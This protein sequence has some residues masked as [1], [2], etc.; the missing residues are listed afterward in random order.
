[1]TGD[2]AVF[3]IFD[4]SM[5]HIDVQNLKCIDARTNLKCIDAQ[6]RR[7]VIPSTAELQVTE[8]EEFGGDT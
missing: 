6:I 3:C 4:D 7:P 8:G 2:V 1:M 5:E